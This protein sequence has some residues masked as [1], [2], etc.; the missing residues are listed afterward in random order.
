MKKYIYNMYKYKCSFKINRKTLIYFTIY[1][2]KYS[3][4]TSWSPS[5][6]AVKSQ[7]MQASGTQT[8]ETVVR[9]SRV[10]CPNG[11]FSVLVKRVLKAIC[12]ITRLRARSVSRPDR[13]S[14][15]RFSASR[16]LT[17]TCFRRCKYSESPFTR[18]V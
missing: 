7:T 1:F 15:H 16:A 10:C 14:C 11:T 5:K 17:R 3:W 6:I 4:S 12:Q 13:H 8:N 9:F 18:I 2:S